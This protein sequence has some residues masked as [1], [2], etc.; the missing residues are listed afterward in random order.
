ML[1]RSDSLEVLYKK[2]VKITVLPDKEAVY[3]DLTVI[4]PN[5]D[6]IVS[7]KI[8]GE[9]HVLAVSWQ[10]DTS[11]YITDSSGVYNTGN[12]LM[13]ITIV[14]DLKT[15]IEYLSKKKS[16]TQLRI[17]QLLGL[18]PLNKKKYFVEFW[19]K[20]ED[21]FRPCPDNEIVDAECELCFPDNTDTT[22]IKWFNSN[23][24]NTYFNCNLYNNFPWTQLG[25]TYDW[26][27]DNKS[28]IGISE[29]VVKKNK[30]IIKHKFYTTKKYLD[31]AN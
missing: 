17:E 20:P 16:L 5:N 28:H 31:Q 30:R 11:Y 2:A 23:R 18:P 13:W 27:P 24:S 25:Y 21:I 9:W 8:N 7:K 1:N 14:P 3:N 29:F 6:N 10:N 19:V 12:Y 15:R 22:Y 4:T 26:N